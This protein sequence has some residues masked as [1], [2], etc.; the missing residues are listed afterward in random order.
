M[1]ARHMRVKITYDDNEISEN[2]A[3]FIKSLDFTDTA[4]N[5]A[6]DIQITLEDRQ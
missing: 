5:E 1:Q 2:L 3:P 6:D 4:S